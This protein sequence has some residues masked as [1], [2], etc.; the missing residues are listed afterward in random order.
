MYAPV[1]ERTKTRA[2]IKRP[3]IID[4]FEPTGKRTKPIITILADYRLESN[5]FLRLVDE[6]RFTD[7]IVEI[8]RK[9]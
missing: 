1:G 3:I 5:S 7:K 4:N 9:L 6:I 8:G 2:R